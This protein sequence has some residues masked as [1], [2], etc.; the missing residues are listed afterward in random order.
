MGVE[1]LSVPQAEA[2]LK[3]L[4]LP[5]T[6]VTEL[7]SHI[8]K[9]KRGEIS[10]EQ[11]QEGLTQLKRPASRQDAAMLTASIGGIGYTV[12][13]LEQ[14]AEDVVSKMNRLN[15]TLGTAFAGLRELAEGSAGQDVE[16]FLR[17]VGC[18]KC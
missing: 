13:C 15:S 6:D 17:K 5:V 14:R 8:D 10:K 1:A 11:F 12:D 4:E 9:D 16:V 2:A 18:I 7:F 3:F